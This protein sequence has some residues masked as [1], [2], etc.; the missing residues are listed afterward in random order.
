MA[1]INSYYSFYRRE[2]IDLRHSRFL[3][4]FKGG[5]TMS[6]PSSQVSQ[7]LFENKHNTR[8]SY[9]RKPG[10]NY[11]SLEMQM[12]LREILKRERAYWVDRQGHIISDFLQ[13]KVVACYPMQ[14]MLLIRLLKCAVEK[15]V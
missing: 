12:H 15:I 8:A 4:T 5:Y 1:I 2:I 14:L 6:L 10:E 13:K 9:Q 7:P 11:M 3:L